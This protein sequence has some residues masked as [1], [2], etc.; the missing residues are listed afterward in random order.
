M[1]PEN[2]ISSLDLNHITTRRSS[3]TFEEAVAVWLMKWAGDFNQ[4]IAAKFGTNQGRIAEILTEKE[5][6]GSREKA[7]TLSSG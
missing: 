7:F 2:Y 4:I 5:H 1:T 3:L 6:I